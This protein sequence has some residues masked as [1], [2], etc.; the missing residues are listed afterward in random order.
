MK[1]LH[2]RPIK[3]FS[4]SGTIYSDSAIWRLKDEYYSLLDFQMRNSGYVTRLDIAPD[5]TLQYNE[6][7]ES[8]SFELSI[9]GIYVGKRKSEWIFGVE[10]NKIIP[11]VQNRL[12]EYSSKVG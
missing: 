1:N 4:L 12:K 10:E 7:T 6:D 9:Y 3:K 11:I 5:F 2:H 8:F